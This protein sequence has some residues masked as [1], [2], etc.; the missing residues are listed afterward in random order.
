M[1]PALAGGDSQSNSFPE[2]FY[3]GLTDDLK[4]R[5]KEHNSGRV[6]HTSKFIPWT[7]ASY[8]AFSNPQKAVD[9]ERYLKSGSGREFAKR[10]LR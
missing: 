7:I 5:L 4:N 2:Q 10:H 8:F 3:T 1:P 9:F 6:T